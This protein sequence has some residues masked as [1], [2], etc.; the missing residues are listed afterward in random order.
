MANTAFLAL[1]E[2]DGIKG[3]STSKQGKDQIEILSFNN[4][5]HM[6]MQHTQSNTS[7]ATGRCQHKDFTVTKLLDLAS[8][9]LYEKCASG[10]EIKS[11][12]LHL[13]KADAKGSP[14]E[15]LTYEFESCLLT[16]VALSGAQVGQPHESLSFNYL[17]VKWTYNQQESAK[18]G[19]KGKSEGGWSIKEN[20]KK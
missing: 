5:Q 20:K 17:T 12:K 9:T 3:E 2:I 7:R 13:Y 11:I 10:E 19:K 6:P 14:L 16:N 1:L 8:P 4:G 18:G 15:F